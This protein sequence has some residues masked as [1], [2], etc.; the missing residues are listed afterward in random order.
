DVRGDVDP[1]VVA[2]VEVL[3]ETP[4]GAQVAAADVEHALAGLEAVAGQVVELHLPQGQPALLVVAAHGLLGIAGGVGGHHRAVVG[5]VVAVGEP[6]P[7]VT[8]GTAQVR[9]DPFGVAHRVAD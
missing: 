2:G 4:P 9:A 8:G 5:D 3:D 7:Q 6:Q 1:V